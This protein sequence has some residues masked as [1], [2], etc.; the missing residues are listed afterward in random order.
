MVASETSSANDFD[1][2]QGKWV[3][4]H[5]KL[6]FR[7]THCT[8]WSEFE[9][10]DENYGSI[11][12]G[13]GNIDRL[14]A[15]FDG[16]PFEGLTLRL[17]NPA[18]RLWSLY[19]VASDKGVLDPPVVGSFVGPVGRFYGKDVFKG[20]PII[21]QFKWDKTN[22]DRPEWSQAFSTDNGQ[23]W[24]WNW[25]NVSFRKPSDNSPVTPQPFVPHRISTDSTEFGSTFSAEGNTFY[26]CRSVNGQSKIYF[27]E[28][29]EGA[30]SEPVAVSFSTQS[31]SDADPA[32]S[33]TGDLYFIS[34]RPRTAKDIRKDYD[35]WKVSS[36][37]R[38]QW[39]TPVN[40]ATLN[41]D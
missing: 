11:L 19:W 29:T 14:R 33:P 38:H 8:E 10:T 15:V 12:N 24:E 3:M 36:R 25:W 41:S 23:T 27:S 7:L 31:Y 4:Q 9:T 13:I 28:Q 22:P 1:F 26:F 40:V 32:F 21:F 30:W 5:K 37:G 16:K 34:D 17:F 39:S 35:I 6:K 18:T 20:I 2:L